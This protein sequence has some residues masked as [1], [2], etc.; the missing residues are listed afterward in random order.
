ME[1]TIT[2]LKLK[3]ISQEDAQ[4]MMDR[5]SYSGAKENARTLRDD[6]DW[7]KENLKRV[8]SFPVVEGSTKLYGEFPTEEAKQ[9][10]L[11]EIS[12]CIDN[13]TDQLKIYKAVVKVLS[14]KKK[15]LL[16]DIR[17]GEMTPEQVKEYVDCFCDYD[18]VGAVVENRWK[19]AMGR[20]GSTS[21][22]IQVGKKKKKRSRLTDGNCLTGDQL[23]IAHIIQAVC[24]VTWEATEV[25]DLQFSL[26]MMYLNI[27][28]I[29]MIRQCI[30]SNILFNKKIFNQ[31]QPL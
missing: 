29:M 17:R 23:D 26:G 20:I 6:L 27:C 22:T 15:E 8:E 18:K 12:E 31:I 1:T 14:A 21:A 25:T 5:T 16:A 7:H 11:K 9:K 19:Y 13:Y 30:F 4:K 2:N 24:R 28:Q 10:K 3:V